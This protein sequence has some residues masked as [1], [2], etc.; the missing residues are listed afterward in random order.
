MSNSEAHID[1]VFSKGL[2]DLKVL[3]PAEVWEGVSSGMSSPL[4]YL[5]R[6][7]A[8]IAV[9]IVA[10]TAYLFLSPP[11]E[12]APLATTGNSP[13]QE[14]T[15]AL[16]T[17]ESSSQ[18]RVNPQLD[19]RPV[20]HLI[21]ADNQEVMG[22]PVLAQ[23]AQLPGIVEAD[24]NTENIFLAQTVL[25]R[26]SGSED[27]YSLQEDRRGLLPEKEM[28][29]YIALPPDPLKVSSWGLNGVFSPIYSYRTNQPNP[30]NQN[31]EYYYDKEAPNY[32]FTG[33]VNALYKQNRRLTFVTGLMYTRSEQVYNDVMFYENIRTGELLETGVLS[34]NV[35]YPIET[36]LGE[37]NSGNSPHLVADFVMPDGN[38]YS[39]DRS[40]LPEFDDYESLNTDLNQ[41]LDFIEVPFMVKY[42]ILDSKLGLNVTSGI[43]TN[44]L[45]NSSV[46]ITHQDQKLDIGTTS[47]LQKVNFLGSLGIGLE[48]S[49]SDKWFLNVEP[50]FKYFINSINVASSQNTHPYYFGIYSGF[51]YFF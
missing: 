45:V 41:R 9:I 43:G 48:Y 30:V 38:R 31:N 3:P 8:S 15:E 42:K 17:L 4:I 25:D 19:N 40:S 27:L 46:Y 13:T 50:T 32:G 2:E 51:S 10:G 1:Q 11:V 36:S 28:Y 12:Q 7:V 20:S 16:T 44:F 39:G 22:S 5:K 34:E 24:Q 6:A 33:G 35:P 23:L 14:N 21:E 18:A 47:G 49:I 37:I 29:P 26:G